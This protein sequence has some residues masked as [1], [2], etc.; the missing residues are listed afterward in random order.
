VAAAAAAAAAAVRDAF[1]RT[2]PRKRGATTRSTTDSSRQPPPL[3]VLPS[4]MTVTDTTTAA[5]AAVVG[6][7]SGAGEAANNSRKKNSPSQSCV[8]QRRRPQQREE[9][10]QQQR[11]RK[12]AGSQSLRSLKE[13]IR[14][15]GW[16]SERIDRMQQAEEETTT[17]TAAVIVDGGETDGEEENIDINRKNG[18]GKNALHVAAWKGSIEIV[19]YLVDEVGCD[20]DAIATGRY[21]YGK[22]PIFFAATRCRDDV[23]LS[24]LRRG[25][26]VKIVNN[27]GQSV[28]SIASSHLRDETV[29][30]VRRV[31]LEQRADDAASWTN[32]RATHS[33]GFVYGDLDPRFYVQEDDVVVVVVERTEFCVNPTT[34]ESRK[35]AFLRR[36]PEHRQLQQQQQQCRNRHASRS[37]KKWRKGSRR[38]GTRALTEEEE[39]RL[40]TASVALERAAASWGEIDNA[41]GIAPSTVAAAERT[42]AVTQ[43]AEQVAV[44]VALSEKKRRSWISEA[45]TR[46]REAVGAATAG[47]PVHVRIS[48]LDRAFDSAASIITCGGV[49][50][51]AAVHDTNG[52]G[53]NDYY[54]V[55]EDGSSVDSNWRRQQRQVKLIERLRARVNEGPPGAERVHGSSTPGQRETS[56]LLEHSIKPC[57]ATGIWSEAREAVQDLSISLLEGLT[58]TINTKGASDEECPIRF[59]TLPRLPTWVDTIEDIEDLQATLEMERLVAFDTEWISTDV[60]RTHGNGPVTVTQ[61][62][63]IQVATACAAREGK[64]WVIDLLV[65]CDEYRRRCR[66]LIHF[67]LETKLLLG[68]AL[69]K[70]VRLIA[71]FL[72]GNEQTM[73][74]NN[75]DGPSYLD[76]SQKARFLDLQLLWRSGGVRRNAVPG[77]AACAREFSPIPLSK[78]EQCSDWSLRPL[79]D[80]QLAYA[81]LDAAV[82]LFILAEGER[83]RIPAEWNHTVG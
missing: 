4:G 32:Y 43:A 63:T 12:A 1:V 37:D 36:N 25:A 13:A 11:L 44:I 9:D 56:H 46:L 52:A 55:D 20:V 10:R 41:T 50:D 57:L 80:S 38:D 67:L 76:V 8:S 77:L 34:K 18:G 74:E 72:D 47:G 64:S 14:D 81:G 19:E 24:L 7:A 60:S 54:S 31:E 71:Q 65:S 75:A 48:L 62:S 35:G 30:A 15:G 73:G 61:I 27:K 49:E 29:A 59:L 70:D 40:R 66:D 69:G 17:E 21:S 39:T 51:I 2:T 42:A 28:L 16:T 68:F 22:T 58:Q 53:N 26:N 6:T 83:K 3:R 82:L 45:A 23:V 79:A 33:D 5:A 78:Q